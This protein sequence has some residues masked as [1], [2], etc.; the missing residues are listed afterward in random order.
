MKT[1]WFAGLQNPD[2][3]EK[4][5][6]MFKRSGTFRRHLIHLIEGK[7]DSADKQARDKESYDS[8][9]WAYKQADFQG[10]SRAL[11]EIINLIS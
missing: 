2:D 1:V 3:K 8:P 5:E 4:I 10:Y 6:S 7:I 9:N 11:H